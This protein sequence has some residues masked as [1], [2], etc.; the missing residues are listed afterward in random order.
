MLWGRAAADDQ[1][2]PRRDR[3]PGRRERGRRWDD[4]RGCARAPPDP[5]HGAALAGLVAESAADRRPGFGPAAG[6][7]DG[8][9]GQQRVDVRGS[10]VH[11]AA[12]QAGFDHQLVGALD[13]PAA[14]WV[15][16]RQELGVAE[17]LPPLREVAQ[18]TVPRRGR[19]G[20]VRRPPTGSARSAVSTVSRSPC[21]S[22]CARAASQVSVAAVPGPRAAWAALARCSTAWAKSS[23]RTA[24]GRWWSRNVW[25]QSAPSIT[26]T[27][28]PAVSVP[29][30]CSSTVA[31]RVKVSWSARREK[32]DSS[33]ACA[34]AAA[35]ASPVP[36]AR[37]LASVQRPPT[38]GIIA[39]S[40]LTCCTCGP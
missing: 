17:L 22:A 28:T 36:M 8:A 10:P 38:S 4:R 33:V 3:K 27:T 26:P 5:P 30:R 34:P 13:G 31:R 9:Q 39:P 19:R 14:D 37:V 23:T 25:S 16:G 40:A 6:A 18:R 1:L 20:G 32:Y 15:A 7:G 29:R 2:G 24:S 21:L 35:S 11:P 12:L